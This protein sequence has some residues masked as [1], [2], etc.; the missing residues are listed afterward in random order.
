MS[1]IEDLKTTKL[2]SQ[3][4]QMNLAMDSV[5][6]EQLANQLISQKIM[7][8]YL[9]KVKVKIETRLGILLI[10]V[11]TYSKKILYCYSLAGSTDTLQRFNTYEDQQRFIYN[12]IIISKERGV[13]PE[14]S[15]LVGRATYYCFTE[16]MISQMN[17][18]WEIKKMGDTLDLLAK[19]IK[20]ISN[21]VNI[22]LE[23]DLEKVNSLTLRSKNRLDGLVKPVTPPIEESQISSNTNSSQQDSSN[24]PKDFLKKNSSL[25]YGVVRVKSIISPA[26]G[27]QFSQLK[28]S[29][30]ILCK[31]IIKTEEDKSLVSTISIE[32]V[33][34]EIAGNFLRY[35]HT[36]N[37]EYHVFYETSN[38]I[39]LH[40]IDS[41]ELKVKVQKKDSPTDGKSSEL[42]TNSLNRKVLLG[43]GLLVVLLILV[44]LLS[45]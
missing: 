45:R 5:G 6:S 44:Y 8:A 21:S 23:G 24:S 4:D 32:E 17:P 31:P 16:E 30:I 39:L 14:L 28:V 12:F 36:S 9:F 10:L 26:D 27:I 40:S 3:V 33:P 38:N 11:S 29:D 41:K 35:F 2:Q 20:E 13:N 18:S 19:K 1:S 22:K 7:D 34:G 25:Y 15:D 37:D 43:V 42:S